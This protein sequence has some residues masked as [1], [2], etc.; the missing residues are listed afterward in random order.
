MEGSQVNAA[1]ARRLAP[2]R[3]KAHSAICDGC[4]DAIVGIR[5]KCLDCPDWDYCTNCVADAAFVHPNHRF[6]PIYENLENA[7]DMQT[8]YASRPIHYGICCDGPLCA[9]AAKSCLVSYIVGDRYKCAVCNDTDFCANCEASP[10]N[11]HNRTHPLIKFKTPVRSV[12]VSTTG[13]HGN[14]QPMPML[15][16]RLPYRP[17]PASTS[18]RATETNNESKQLSTNL[19]T[20]VDVEP[21]EPSEPTV[22]VKVEAKQAEAEQEPKKPVVAA[23]KVSCEKE[24]VATY[25]RDTIADG[26][27]FPPHTVFEQTWLLRN[28]GETAWPAGCSVKYMSGDYMGHLDPDHPAAIGELVSSSES[29]ISY[30]PVAPGEQVS[31]TVLLR[32]PIRSGRYVS[33][34]RLTTKDGLRFGHRLWCDIA[35]ERPVDVKKE[36]ELELPTRASSSSVETKME[37]SQMI[38]PKLE[39]E[40]PV[41][42][43]YAPAPASL[44]APS[45]AAEEEDEFEDCAQDEGWAEDESEEGFLTDE[46]YDVLDASDEEYLEEQNKKVFKK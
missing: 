30:A 32:S 20:V 22:P 9:S 18:S 26:T 46:E 43:I 16:D 25:Q 21:L 13:E 5:H 38:F 41:S 35:V 27:V 12:S 36:E 11:E 15:G 33:N 34:W 1:V 31:F 37:E 45:T 10:A 7:A 23:E 44:A 2:G 8:R 4:D 29:T 19:L 28:D 42:S 3:A 40:S 39:K 17:A 14:G 6:V 24:L